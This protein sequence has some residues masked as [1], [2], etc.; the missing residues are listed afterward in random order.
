MT[1]TVIKIGSGGDVANGEAIWPLIKSG[2]INQANLL[3]LQYVPGIYTGHNAT[4]G[5]RYVN[6]VV[7]APWGPV[8]LK[9][10]PGVS[11]PYDGHT[12]NA[13]WSNKGLIVYGDGSLTI[14]DLEIS[15]ADA[16]GSTTG[17]NWA[18]IRVNWPG[19]LTLL[20]VN[21]HDCNNGVLGGADGTNFWMQDSTVYRCGDGG[22][23]T[24]NLYLS[25][26]DTAVLVNNHSYDCRTGHNYK[27]R[28]AVHI[29]VNND[30]QDTDQAQT[31]SA[32]ADISAGIAVI[33]HNKFRKSTGTGN[34]GKII[35]YYTDRDQ[36]RDNYLF[37]QGNTFD[38]NVA[39]RGSFI[40]VDNNHRVSYPTGTI[41]GTVPVSGLIKD[42]D[43]RYLNNKLNYAYHPFNFQ[44]NS[45]DDITLGS[46]R[47]ARNDLSLTDVPYGCNFNISE[48]NFMDPTQLNNALAALAAVADL[49]QDDSAASGVVQAQLDTANAQITALQAKITAAKADLN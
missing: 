35:Y 42:N 48:L 17:T 28:A 9:G 33:V 3:R 43:C 26:F 32:N 13:S 20:G 10:T 27:S 19:D 34:F 22:G 41:D 21:I 16:T 4:L 40:K 5:L 37:V 25:R 23:Q 46:N 30:F 6:T 8:H 12:W 11:L 7:E 47:I 44:A 38:A 49:L 18:G 24:H 36:D 45:D 2:S 29:L 31:S 1:E 14:K 39:F 15:H